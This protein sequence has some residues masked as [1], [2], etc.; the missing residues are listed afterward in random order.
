MKHFELVEVQRVR[1]WDRET[2]TE[3]EAGQRQRQRPEARTQPQVLAWRMGVIIAIIEPLNK[4]YKRYLAHE[5]STILENK[6]SQ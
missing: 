5:L 6:G 2:K 3:A 1:E 4:S